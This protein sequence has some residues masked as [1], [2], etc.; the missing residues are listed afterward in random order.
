MHRLELNIQNPIE[1]AFSIVCHDDR[2]D[3]S[4]LNLVS[5]LFL[6]DILVS[7]VDVADLIE[8]SLTSD[9]FTSRID[10]QKHPS[11]TFHKVR[12]ETFVHFEVIDRFGI[13]SSEIFAC[14]ADLDVSQSTHDAS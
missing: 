6:I 12:S 4:L 11:I 13:S 10:P 7:L 3:K 14:T 5:L 8:D 1:S 9:Y 2:V